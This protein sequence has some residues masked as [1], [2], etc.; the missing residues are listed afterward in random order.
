MIDALTDAENKRKAYAGQDDPFLSWAGNQKPALQARDQE[1]ESLSQ[2]YRSALNPYIADGYDPTTYRLNEEAHN[3]SLVIA[4]NLSLLDAAEQRRANALNQ[5]GQDIQRQMGYADQSKQQE[6]AIE[7][8]TESAAQTAKEAERYTGQEKRV[9]E[10][11]K[12]AHK[13]V[14]QSLNNISTITGS[15]DKKKPANTNMVSSSTPATTGN[16]ISTTN[17]TRL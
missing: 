14:Q 16:T 4:H 11:Q 7:R 13:A 5:L 17:E 12:A 6:R 1:Y 8:T 10:A 3:D 2:G 15:K 9:T